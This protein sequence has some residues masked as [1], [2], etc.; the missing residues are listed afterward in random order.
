M[1]AG[2]PTNAARW[3]G[4]RVRLLLLVSSAVLPAFALL[5]WTT[6]DHRAIR[7]GEAETLAE[8]LAHHAAVEFGQIVESTRETLARL[9]RDADVRN[10]A[11]GDACN[12]TLARLR[13]LNA[14]YGV[15]GVIDPTGRTVCA[16]TPAAIGKDLGDRDYFQRALRTR[17]FAVSGFLVGRTSKLNILIAAAPLGEAGGPVE[18]VLFLSL[19]LDWVRQQMEQMVV[20]EGTTMMLVDGRGTIMA[21]YP[22]P[23]AFLGHEIPQAQAFLDEGRRSGRVAATRVP[24]LDG[25]ERVIAGMALPG[26]PHGSAFARAGVPTADFTQQANDA[27]ARNLLL[28]AG[29][30]LLVYAAA[31][32]VAARLVVKPTRR[33]IEAAESLGSGNLGARTGLK[34]G[35]DE[36]G[37]LAM[38]FD[39]MAARVERVT[40]ALRALSACNSSL[41]HARSETQ[42]LDE[43]VRIAVSDGDYVVAWVGLLDGAEPPRL[44]TAALAGR[45]DGVSRAVAAQAEHDPGAAASLALGSDRTRCIGEH[46]SPHLQ[47]ALHACALP[48]RVHGRAIG[49]LQLCTDNASAFDAAEL[50]LLEEMAADL[51]FGLQTLRDRARHAHAEEKIQ[52][53]AF[54]DG[55]TGLP[56]RASLEVTAAQMLHDA[57][58]AKESVAVIVV[59]LVRF[60]RIQNAIGFAEADRLIV[61]V[62]RRLR[63]M[64]LPAWALA[65]VGGDRFALVLPSTDA[66]SARIAAARLAREFERPFAMAGIDIEAPA[67]LGIAVFPLHGADAALLLRRADV[68]CTD[69]EAQG[70]EVELYRGE[71][72]KENPARLQ[73]MVDLRRAIDAGQ[74]ELHYQGKVDARTGA[75][76]GA[77]A[78][79]RWRHPAKG[80]V[81][82][83][84]FI[85]DAEETGLI[86]PLTRWVMQA[87]VRQLREWSMAGQAIPVAVNLSGRNF[88]DPS[89]A[90]DLARWLESAGVPASLLQIEITETVLMD[91]TAATRHAIERLREAGHPILIDDFG[92]GYSSLRYLA[93]MP[94]DAIKIDRSFVV[95]IVARSEMRALVG[96]IVDM[97][98]TLGLK[99]VAEGVD[100]EAQ[101]VLLR[102]MG[103]DEIQGFLYARPVPARTFLAWVAGRPVA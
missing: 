83:G 9:S 50:E 17:S 78:L 101:A 97:G 88:R 70:S 31:W 22:D 63:A 35:A 57:A 91:D 64:A 80:D 94:V 26:T 58:A 53:M 29:V 72:A 7:L 6:Y 73:L 90:V 52:Q 95:E 47:A 55:L 25:Q 23:H 18:G 54:V 61:E 71:S 84:Q 77:E 36:L 100:D 20:P 1:A 43:L 44:V 28:Q 49:V 42:L 3:R 56:N 2:E 45:D 75:V 41:L 60:G 87:V 89:L 37:R 65:R 24:G 59:G 13:S 38:H 11:D 68:A 30:A 8:G 74:L 79:L 81:P 69:A 67:T 48:L 39:T 99:L 27:L 66:I 92:T 85:P 4:L 98:H 82:P 76:T 46:V 103:C 10:F 86:A 21:S 32:W 102:E 15:I 93:S 62:A 19:D 16:D 12:R 51:S 14:A 33:L 96:A 5:A 40:R 34:H